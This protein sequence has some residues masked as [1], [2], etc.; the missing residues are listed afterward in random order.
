M[1]LGG[2]SGEPESQV[3]G[4]GEVGRSRENMTMRGRTHKLGGRSWGRASRQGPMPRGC[5][6]GPPS[7]GEGEGSAGACV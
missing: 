5:G 6:V 7:S 3:E 2:Q 1:R 4:L